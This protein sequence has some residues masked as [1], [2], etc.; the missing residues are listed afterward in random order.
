MHRQAIFLWGTWPHI[1]GYPFLSADNLCQ[2][3]GLNTGNLVFSYAIQKQLDM[4]K[5]HD[6][7]KND[8]ITN[9]LT[10]ANQLNSEVDMGF[11]ADI[12]NKSS[13]PVLAI[14]LGAQSMSDNIPQLKDGTI[15][16]L[17]AIKEHK[18]TDNYPN[19]TL[20]GY[21]TQKVM[22][23]YGFGDA[24]L[25]LG[26]PSLFIAPNLNLGHEIAKNIMK[27]K[28]V[29]VLGGHSWHKSLYTIERSLVNLVQLT[30][31]AY[32]VQSDE[33]MLKFARR[34]INGFTDATFAKYQNFLMPCGS[35]DTFLGWWRQY[36]HVFYD[37]EAWLEF[38]KNYDFAIG[39]RIHGVILAMQ[40][41][42]PAV[43]IAYDSRTKE[44]CEVM[45]IPFVLPV[46]I[47]HGVVLEKLDSLF[48]K[49]D[50]E[51]F[52]SNRKKLGRQYIDFLIRNN[53]HINSEF[54]DL[55]H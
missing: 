30:N 27:E 44:L 39:A 28:R 51:E 2:Y 50:P 53:V 20:R 22:D 16:W 32:I 15:N 21:F 46:D 13:N 18:F 41:G 48:E 17:R 29:V 26:C 5:R 9:I 7:D 3:T 37:V 34:D 4:S 8:N 1:D 38:Y 25:V 49:F 43:C 14:G 45:K 11:L 36:G 10:C 23:Q 55:F 42:L 19:I 31:G 35:R 33:P 24:G 52:D 54:M 6:G 47:A 12:I 40:A